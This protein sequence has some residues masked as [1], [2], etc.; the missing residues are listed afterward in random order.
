M[1]EQIDTRYK[2]IANAICCHRIG[3][4]LIDCGPAASIDNVIDALGDL[5]PSVLLLTHIHLDHAGGAGRLVEHFPEL[6]VYIHEDAVKHLIDP[7]RLLA[8]AERVF[9]ERIAE[10]GETLPVPAE[11][12]HAISPGDVIEGL[13]A[14]PTPGHSGHHLAFFHELSKTALVGDLVGQALAP[15]HL[16]LMSTPPPEI[17]VEQWLASIDRV[18]ER[19]PSTLALTH[20][21]RITDVAGQC[22]RAKRELRR[23]S[24]HAS[25]DNQEQ[26]VTYLERE[27][28][29]VPPEV[30]ES[31]VSSLPSL[32]QLYMGYDRYWSK[33]AGAEAAAA[34]S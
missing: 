1:I 26:F 11:N 32:D 34:G 9:G 12:V 28:E 7:S 27:L 17:D 5:V 30:A 20:F 13:E 19:Y 3:D 31:L 2:G 6:R 25:E 29:T 4:V 10:W 15:H 21:G 22:E 16:T 18:A 23:G 14:I 33:R 24:E 8:S